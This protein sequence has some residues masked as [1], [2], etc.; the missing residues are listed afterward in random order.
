MT[1]NGAKSVGWTDCGKDSKGKQ[2]Y[3]NLFGLRHIEIT[4]A[5]NDMFNRAAQ[6][7]KGSELVALYYGGVREPIL[8]NAEHSKQ[9]L[10][11]AG[12]RKPQSDIIVMPD[13][14]V[15]LPII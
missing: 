2:V 10:L 6:T 7:P 1:E 9:F 8:L 12:L 13:A 5:D 11:A 3:V 15:K 14:D 4:N